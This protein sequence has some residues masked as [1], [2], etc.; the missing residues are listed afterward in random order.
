MQLTRY[1][2]KRKTNT[3][4]PSQ[5]HSANVKAARENLDRLHRDVLR[6]VGKGIGEMVRYDNGVR[7]KQH[8]ENQEKG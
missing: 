2:S 8:G 1:A 7:E 4:S 3:R 6:L 5:E